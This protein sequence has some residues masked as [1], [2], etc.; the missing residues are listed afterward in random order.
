MV[1]HARTNSIVAAI[2]IMTGIDFS[3]LR[4][5]KS[6]MTPTTAQKDVSSCMNIVQYVW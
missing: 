2:E 1:G 5:T 6:L 3:L 4:A